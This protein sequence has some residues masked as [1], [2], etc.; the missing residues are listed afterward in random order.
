MNKKLFMLSVILPGKESSKKALQRRAC[1]RSLYYSVSLCGI[2][3]V[4]GRLA[5]CAGARRHAVG[6]G[7]N[8]MMSSIFIWQVARSVEVCP[9]MGHAPMISD[10]LTL[11]EGRWKANTE[12]RG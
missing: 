3:F 12:E 7:K 1:C 9:V 4:A 6:V 8:T 11:G 2:G 10:Q 5:Y